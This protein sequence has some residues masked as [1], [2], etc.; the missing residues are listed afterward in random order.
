[1]KK[2]VLIVGTRPNYIKAFPVYEALKNNFNLTLIHTGQHYDHN[3]NELFFNEL[4]M[5]KPDIQFTL[6]KSGE[7]LQLVEIIN[8]LHD[9]FKKSKPD[10]VIVFGDVTSTLAGAL[11]ANKLKIKVA[12]VESGLRSFDM[13]MP[14]EINRIMIDNISEYLFVTEQTGLDNLVASGCVG[15]KFLVGNTMIDTLVKFNNA[16]KTDKILDEDFIVCT[17]H[18]QS[19]VD[20]PE[21]L[22]YII[23]HLNIMAQTHKFIF[24]IHHRTKQKVKDLNLEFH[25]NIK[26]LDP[27]GY[28][29]FMKYIKKAKLVVTDSGGVQEE[30][31][32]L[33]I[34]CITLRNSTER[35][36]TLVANGGSSILA[37]IDELPDYINE[38][39]GKKSNTKIHLWDGC[40]GQRICENLM[41]V[42]G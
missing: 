18:R 1:M 14:E 5:K 19:N 28:I 41:Q 21:V 33:G 12:H 26:L 20:N 35:P 37:T 40:A 9:V 29:D 30:T 31:S 7:C 23:K 24:P 8:K 15:K 27:L 4:G 36:A 39:Y 42:L 10:L 38:Y 16:I 17:I 13:T 25:P 32:F 3:M 2:I 22:A 34:Y 6:E 11:T